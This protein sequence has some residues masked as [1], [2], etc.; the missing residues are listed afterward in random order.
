MPIRLA[1]VSRNV[2]V[3]DT[4]KCYRSYGRDSNTASN[5]ETDNAQAWPGLKSWEGLS[6]K[7]GFTLKALPCEEDYSLNPVPGKT[8]LGA[9]HRLW[10]NKWYCYMTCQSVILR[11]KRRPQS[12]ATAAESEKGN[13][14]T[15][16]FPFAFWESSILIY[17][18]KYGIK[19]KRIKIKI[20]GV[21]QIKHKVDQD[22][23]PNI[24][25]PCQGSRS[26]GARSLS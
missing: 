6:L 11:S 20:C 15:G 16:L 3:P 2:K 25:H 10:T 12:T 4:Y 24:I 9:C 8:R 7:P 17:R 26:K 18:I 19:I 23:M 13:Y 1:G 5:A 21:D 14:P 22:Q